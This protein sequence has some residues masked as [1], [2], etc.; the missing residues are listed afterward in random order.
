MR[1]CSYYPP[2]QQTMGFQPYQQQGSILLVLKSCFQ[3]LNPLLSIGKQHGPIR[4]AAG[5]SQGWAN[6][7]LWASYNHISN[8]VVFYGLYAL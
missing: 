5:C 6:T 2:L 4:K 3:K 8:K 1:P 7:Q